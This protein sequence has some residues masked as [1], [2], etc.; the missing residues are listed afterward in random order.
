MLRKTNTTGVTTTGHYVILWIKD[1]N[2]WK[3][4]HMDMTKAGN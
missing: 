4:K 2:D 3:I 1:G